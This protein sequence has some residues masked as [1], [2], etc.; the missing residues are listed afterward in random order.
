MAGARRSR[1]GLGPF[2][3]L[4]SFFLG[5]EGAWGAEAEPAPLSLS[6][7]F[8]P[9]LGNTASCQRTC[10]DTYPLHTYPKEEELYACQRGCRLFSICQF[11]DDGI[12][13]NQ[14]KLECDSACSEAYTSQSDEQYAC[15][16]G[17]QN[18]LPYAELRREQLMSLMPRM[19]LLFPLTFVRSF[20]SDMMETAHSFITSSWT[21]YLQAD[22]GKILIFQAKPQVQY[23]ESSDQENLNLKESS[24]NKAALDLPPGSPQNHKGFFDDDES[25][26][27]FKCISVNSGWILTT[28]LLLS[29]LVLLW[30]C[31]ATVTTAVEQYVPSEKLSIYGDL[32]YMNEQKLNRYPTSALMVVK[33]KADEQEAG[34]LPTKVNLA[35]S[36]I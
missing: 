22:D 12:D 14:T 6:E 2:L 7:A 8:E 20:W 16:L 27:F 10:Q 9:A 4:L 17:C 33:C 15:H 25:D 5:C 36:S 26:G 23:V 11:A 13:L 1:L 34:P 3:F 24:L 30:I 35:Q 28:T 32:E 31:C 21:F 18:Q 19:H 29:V